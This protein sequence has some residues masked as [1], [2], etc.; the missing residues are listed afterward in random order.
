VIA[1]LIGAGSA[2]PAAAATTYPVNWDTLSAV[3][4]GAADEAAPAGA[5]HL[6]CRPS[7]AHPDPVI[8][9][10]G[11][12]ANEN[13]AWQ[14]LAPT[15]ANNGYCAYTLNYGQVWYSGT[16]GGIGEINSSAS[17]LNAFVNTVLAWTGAS[18][19]DLV[20]HSEGG[21]LARLYMKTYGSTKVSK[22]VGLAPINMGPPTLSGLATVIAQI[23]GGSAAFASGCPAC[24]ELLTPSYFTS[25]NTPSPTY[26]NVTYTD[27]ATVNDEAVTPY[28]LS[29]LPTAPN[30]TNETVQT[31][32]PMDSVGHLGLTY[33]KTAVQLTLNALD[34]AH[35]GA[36]PCS[37]GFPL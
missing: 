24:G 13:I 27:I 1:A 21:N 32:C 30:V 9:I 3:A 36:I 10:H 26:S 18:K 14:A 31:F 7:A 20:G 11:V 29:F 4:I 34:P 23:P 16:L 2:A 17:T 25:L 22:Y 15:L 35:P 37:P 6:F 8:L 28:Q 12:L 5:D 19:V 33:D